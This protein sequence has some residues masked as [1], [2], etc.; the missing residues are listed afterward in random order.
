MKLYLFQETGEFRIAQ[1]GEW[2][3][4]VN[5]DFIQSEGPST[6]RRPIVVITKIEIPNDIM[7][8]AVQPCYSI[9]SERLP[10]FTTHIPVVRPEA[11]VKKWQWLFQSENCDRITA[12]EHWYTKREIEDIFKNQCMKL[13]KK[14]EE[15]E[16]LLE[17]SENDI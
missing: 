12:T 11:K 9:S 16:T 7:Y 17:E 5:G 15:S 6:L 3:Q 1:G 13:L 10:Y 2:Y 14:I 4:D 8:V